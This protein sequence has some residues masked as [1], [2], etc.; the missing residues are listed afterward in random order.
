MTHRMNCTV[1]LGRQCSCG[2]LTVTVVC[3]KTIVSG[4]LKGHTVEMSYTTT[5]A[6]AALD[7]AAINARADE[8]R[9]ATPYSGGPCRKYNARIES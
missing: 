1:Y 9:P 5:P 2:E 4:V 7:V 6:Q 8:I 3:T